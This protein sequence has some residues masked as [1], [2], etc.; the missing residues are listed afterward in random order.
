MLRETRLCRLYKEKIEQIERELVQDC[1]IVNK[2]GKQTM[3]FRT[4]RNSISHFDYEFNDEE[5]MIIFHDGLNECKEIT[6][7]I[8]IN[9]LNKHIRKIYQ[10][11]LLDFYRDNQ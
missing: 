10:Q 2:T 4:I 5:N 11:I 3:S 1:T 8:D 9:T 6:F 7:K